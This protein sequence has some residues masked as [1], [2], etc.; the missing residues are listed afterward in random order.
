MDKRLFCGANKSIRLVT[1]T[2]CWRVLD[3]SPWRLR[4][5]PSGVRA[6]CSDKPAKIGDRVMGEFEAFWKAY[7]RKT[8]KLAAQKAFMKAR[9]TASLEELLRGVT[10]YVRHKPSYADYCH[11]TTFLSQGRWMDEY[12]TAQPEP[13]EDWFQECKRIHGGACGLSQHAHH[14]RKVI[15]EEKAKR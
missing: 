2:S 6:R 15:D 9:K 14:I 5:F 11:P 1:D 4:A 3:R 13:A 12:K 7:P 10:E 8:G